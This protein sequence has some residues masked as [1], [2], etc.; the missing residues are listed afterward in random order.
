MFKNSFNL[1][2]VKKDKELG[3]GINPRKEALKIALIY[4]ILGV[5]WIKTSD[6]LLERLAKDN[7]VYWAIQTYKGWIYV[8]ITMCVIYILIAKKILLLEKAF[9]ELNNSNR[10]LDKLA[11]YD[12]LSNLPNSAFFKLKVNELIDNKDIKNNKF[13]LVYIDIDDFK[14]INNTLG[15]TLG[16][17]LIVYISNILNIKLKKRILWLGLA[18]MNLQFFLLI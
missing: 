8:L 1:R 10:K 11:Y 16:D 2:K 13:A 3:A 4:L 18:E 7:R 15:H 12:T 6:F 9:V 17:K 5:S 14:N